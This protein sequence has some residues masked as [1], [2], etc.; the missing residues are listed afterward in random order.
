[1]P[2]GDLANFFIV[3]PGDSAGTL[4]S[5]LDRNLTNISIDHCL[6][7]IGWFEL[8][9]IVS[10]DGFGNVIFIPKDIADQSLLD[11]CASHFARTLEGG[12]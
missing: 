10:D 12:S 7:H 5:A 8:V 6:S 4:E 11:F 9:S 3:E 1:M 2:L